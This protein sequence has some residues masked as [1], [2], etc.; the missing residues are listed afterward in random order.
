MLTR[1]FGLE[2]L[3]LRA[4][5][6]DAGFDRRV[7]AEMIGPLDRYSDLDLDLGGVDVPALRPF[8]GRWRADLIAAEFLNDARATLL[9]WALVVARHLDLDV[10]SRPSE[11]VDLIGEGRSVTVGAGLQWRSSRVPTI[12]L[13]LGLRPGATMTPSVI[14]AG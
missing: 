6:T 8:F 10:V 11:R 2:T 3:L 7:L 4:K 14:P 13:P 1:R 5:E 9:A 12:D